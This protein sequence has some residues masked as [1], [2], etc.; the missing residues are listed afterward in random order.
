MYSQPW[1]PTPSTTADATAAHSLAH[2]VVRFADELELDTVGE[3]RAEALAGCSFEAC[4]QAAGRRR[5]GE[6]A[7]DLDAEARAHGSVAVGDVVAQVE[8]PRL[9]ENRRR[10]VGQ[11]RTEVSA[12]RLDV[13]LCFE[14][15]CR[16]AEESADFERGRASLGDVLA[17][18]Q[19]SAADRLVVAVQTE[20]RQQ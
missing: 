4:T 16:D 1:S 15:A 8:D 14:A 17:N 3:E 5:R 6:A 11:S 12:V 7:P 19:I 10:V 20:C 13:R 2:I 9:L 18:Q